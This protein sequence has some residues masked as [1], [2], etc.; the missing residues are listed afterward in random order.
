MPESQIPFSRF[1]SYDNITWTFFY[2]DFRNNLCIGNTEEI[3]YNA[4]YEQNTLLIHF[5]IFRLHKIEWN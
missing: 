3:E 4:V 1:V 2:E 5:N